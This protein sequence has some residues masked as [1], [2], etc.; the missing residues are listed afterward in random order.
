MI[1]PKCGSEMPEGTRFCINCGTPMQS[2]PAT[3]VQD[4]APVQPVNPVQN[5]VPV[6]PV[7][8]VQN[9]AP[10]QPATPVQNTVPIQSATPVQNTIPY[11]RGHLPGGRSRFWHLYSRDF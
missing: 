11:Y 6:Q 4:N 10:V 7:T 9:A 8:P 2:A 1:C 5:T 3:P